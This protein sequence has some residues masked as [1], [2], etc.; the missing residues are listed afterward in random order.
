MIVST[1]NFNF[2]K[3]FLWEM[4]SSHVMFKNAIKALRATNTGV[5]TEKEALLTLAVHQKKK[6]KKNNKKE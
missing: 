1:S 4:Y 2:K 5:L 6:K 3:H